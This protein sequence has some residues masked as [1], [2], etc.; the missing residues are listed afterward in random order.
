MPYTQKTRIDVE[1][2]AYTLANDPSHALDTTT[3]HTLLNEIYLRYAHTILAERSKSLGGVATFASGDY[4][5]NSTVTG[6]IELQSLEAAAPGTGGEH[7]SSNRLKPIEKDDFYAVIAD[8][9]NFAGTNSTV[10]LRWGAVKL[11]DSLH[12]RVAIFPPASGSVVVYGWGR[13]EVT[14][15]AADGDP[16]DMNDIDAM[17]L[18]RLLAAQI[19]DINGDSPDDIQGVIAPVSQTIRE[20]MGFIQR[21]VPRTIQQKEKL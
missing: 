6:I 14:P 13:A 16:V 17:N 4:V 5:I 12:W 7:S 3:C 9:E 20:K 2:L 1:N 8:A 18:T 11:Q 10:P 15:L 19:M 21:Q